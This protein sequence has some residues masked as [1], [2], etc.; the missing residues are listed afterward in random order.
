M[1]TKITIA[2]QYAQVEK[3][4]R[5]NGKNSM[6]DFIAERCELHTK[7]NSSKSS[8]PTKAQI[9]NEGIKDEI[10]AVLGAEP[11][12]ASEIAAEVGVSTAKAAA[13]LKQIPEVV[14]IKGKGKNPTTYVIAE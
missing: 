2:E 10:K 13:L 12:T 11:R 1:A 5:E 6:A 14:A 9:E 8:K 4:L 7:R 3:F